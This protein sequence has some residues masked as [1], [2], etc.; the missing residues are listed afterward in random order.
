MEGAI[1]WVDIDAHKK[2]LAVAVLAPGAKVA[3]EFTVDNTET[4]IRKLVRRVQKL[5]RGTEI[6]ACYEAGTCGFALQRRL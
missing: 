4:A 1:T 6:R 5:A 3:E 2:T